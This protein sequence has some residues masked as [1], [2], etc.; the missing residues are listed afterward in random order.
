MTGKPHAFFRDI[1]SIDQESYFHFEPALINGFRIKYLLNSFLQTGAFRGDLLLGKK[2]NTPKRLFHGSNAGS[3]ILLQLLPFIPAHPVK[4]IQSLADRPLGNLPL[5]FIGTIQ[6]GLLKHLREPEEVFQFDGLPRLH[7]LSEL[8]QELIVLPRGRSINDKRE[9]A[10]LLPFHGYR[11]TDLPPGDFLP[12]NLFDVILSKGKGTGKTGRDFKEPAVDTADFDGYRN[13]FPARLTPPIAG[14]A[15]YHASSMWAFH[16]KNTNTGPDLQWKLWH[17]FHTGSSTGY[18]HRNSCSFA[19]GAF[20]NILLITMMSNYYTLSL[21][22]DDLDERLRGR[23]IEETF[24]QEKCELVL[25]FSGL[26]QVLIISCLPRINTLYM[27]P[28]FSRSRK[29]STQVL[30]S[31][32]GKTIL[33]VSIRPMDRVVSFYLQSGLALH[34]SLYGPKANV[35]VTDER[36]EIIDGFKGAQSLLGTRYEPSRSQSVQ[37]LTVLHTLISQDPDGRIQA[38]LKQALPHLGST[39]AQEILYRSAVSGDSRGRDISGQ[40]LELIKNQYAAVIEELS[41]PVPRVYVTRDAQHTPHLFSLVKLE[42]CFDSDERPFPD[43]HEALRFF[44][45]RTRS[46]DAFQSRSRKVLNTLTHGRQK[47]QRALEAV[48]T[49]LQTNSRAAEYDKYG[50]LLMSNL[51]S[52]PKGLEAVTLEDGQTSVTVHL[53][54]TLS[55][56][57]NAQRYFEK[58][59]KSKIA[60]AQSQKRSLEMR[61]TLHRLERLIV[62][63]E[64]IRSPEDLKSF[65]AEHAQELE[66]AGVGEKAKQREQVPFR[67]FTVDGGYQVWAGKSS[68]NNDELT[69]KFSKP[70]DLWFHARGGSGSHVVLKAA[71]GRAGPSRKALEQAAAIAAYYSKMRNAKVVPVAMTD[72]KYVRKPK[73]G[74][75]GSVIIDREKVIFAEPGLPE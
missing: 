30:K 16:V 21:I 69:L 28:N 65:L 64:T 56:V 51:S 49:D 24:T 75:P 46:T 60:L 12:D 10:V 42:H 32:A 58:A 54:P 68:R 73:G 15:G 36:S 2:L 26:S 50:R 20:F 70:N 67:I 35:L 22:A 62:A 8:A 4:I 39:L 43:I 53:D 34:A 14:H 41:T 5:L 55:P 38:L 25:P 59:K 48:E 11:Q 7:G 1:K 27:H 74:A 9:L 18:P 17:I 40:Q 57:Q 44:I 19:N 29:N 13:P 33:S 71:W 66:E 63:A 6:C 31:I 45:S 47:L 3:E 72:R 52:V 23:G 61:K 37:N